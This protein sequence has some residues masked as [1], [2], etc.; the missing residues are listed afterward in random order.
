MATKAVLTTALFDQLNSFT[1]ELIGMYPND[2]DFPLFA[3]TVRMLKMTNPSF[4]VKNIYD[5][6]IP[7]EKKILTKDE[8][9]FMEY[10]FSEFEKEVEDINVF[11]KLKKYIE[12]MSPVSKDGV[13]KY[14]Q[15]ICRL[16][17]AIIEI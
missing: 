14:I 13:W 8:A 16:A 1:S 15:N 2:P 5:N 4:L 11:S 7:F 12:N 3:T 17:K 6:T 10:S 9:F